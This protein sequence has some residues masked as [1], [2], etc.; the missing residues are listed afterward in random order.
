[1]TAPPVVEFA[2]ATKR[3]GATVAV[4]ALSL[5]IEPGRVV[6]LVGRN[7]AGKTTSLRMLLGLTRPT[8]GTARV[9]G[10]E[11]AELPGAARRIG[12]TMDGIGATPGATGL[13]D[14][15]IWA[16][17]LDV[18][19]RRVTEV[20]DLV[21]LADSAHQRVKTYSTGMKQ[22]LALATA[23]LP[24]PELL[25]LDEP[26]NG[27]DPDGVHWL[28]AVLRD[29]AAEGRTVLLSSHHLSELEQTVDDVVVLQQSVRFAG[30]LRELTGDGAARL[31]DRFF[32]VTETRPGGRHAYVD[33]R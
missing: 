13:R 7:G 11:Y 3:F 33:G 25:L 26:S 24:D 9:F 19:A 16:R 12:V 14:L 27:L 1:M 31:E 2:E 4:E 29:L 6:G 18:P 23:L 17:A 8:S 15:T 32:A 30:P 21:G 5:R 20:L 22:R 10:S 28:R